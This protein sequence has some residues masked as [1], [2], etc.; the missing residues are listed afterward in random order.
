MMDALDFVAWQRRGDDWVMDN[1]LCAVCFCVCGK[2]TK[3]KV[4]PVTAN[5]GSVA[6]PFR[7]R[8]LLAF[9]INYIH[10]ENYTAFYVEILPKT[11]PTPVKQSP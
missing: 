8:G 10:T 11:L 2:T 9:S 7:L 3:N 5:N 1:G 4:R 6:A